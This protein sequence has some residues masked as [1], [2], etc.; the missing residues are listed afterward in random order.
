MPSLEED[1]LVIAGR[2]ATGNTLEDGLLR[3]IAAEVE[4]P[5]PVYHGPPKPTI[6]ET[7]G[8]FLVNAVAGAFAISFIIGGGN[9]WNKRYESDL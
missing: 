6:L 3:I 4:P 7:A 9:A 5:R 2:N 1:L 8:N